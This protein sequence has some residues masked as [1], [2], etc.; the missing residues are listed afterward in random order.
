VLI[1]GE[2]KVLK[3]IS[4]SHPSTERAALEKIKDKI[5]YN[6]GY[7]RK[8]QCGPFPPLRCRQSSGKR[9]VAVRNVTAALET[10]WRVGI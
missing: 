4:R 6:K 2:R 10:K 7:I 1:G 8:L 5:R 3:G 9:R